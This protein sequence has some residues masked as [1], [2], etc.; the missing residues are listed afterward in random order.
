[1]PDNKSRH[2]PADRRRV[3]GGETYEAGYFSRKTGLPLHKEATF[4]PHHHPRCGIG[5]LKLQTNQEHNYE[6]VGGSDGP[7]WRRGDWQSIV[8]ATFIGIAIAASASLA[9]AAIA[10]AAMFSWRLW[11]RL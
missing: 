4:F 11:I 9:P 10:A 5:V 7:A 8:A 3:A 6:M 2:G 1:M